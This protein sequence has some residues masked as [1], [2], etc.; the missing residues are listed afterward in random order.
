MYGSCEYQICGSGSELWYRCTV[1]IQTAPHA[2]TVVEAFE[3]AVSPI[4]HEPR[5]QVQ[6]AVRR[7]ESSDLIDLSCTAST[8][9]PQLDDAAAHTG[10]CTSGDVLVKYYSHMCFCLS[11]RKYTGPCSLSQ[12]KAH[13]VLSQKPA[14]NSSSRGC[15]SSSV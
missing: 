4:N 11:W 8:G 2:E 5:E 7:L 10:T 13:M 15:T 3:F 12:P 14:E 1:V 6:Y 9:M